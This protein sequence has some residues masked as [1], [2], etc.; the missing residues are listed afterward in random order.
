MMP[1]VRLT[2]LE[3]RGTQLMYTIDI[4]ASFPTVSALERPSLGM[5]ISKGLA[6]AMSECGQAR[7]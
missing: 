5:R 7:M 1:G 2:A 6:H 4:S 3:T